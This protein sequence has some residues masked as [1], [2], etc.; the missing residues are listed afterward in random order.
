MF[1][2]C[3]GHQLLGAASGAT[4]KL[5]VRPPRRQPPG[6]APGHRQVEITSQ[7]HNF[8]VADD[9]TGAGSEV[10]HV[11]LNDGVVEGLRADRRPPSASSTTPR[12]GPGR[13]TP[14]YLFDRV[15]RA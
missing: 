10:T 12:P 6:A 14:A 1:G 15:R 11:N 2:I 13:T 3:L 8:A 7:N 5:P 9:P 4:Y